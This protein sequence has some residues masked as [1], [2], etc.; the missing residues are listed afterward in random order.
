LK[1]RN[2]RF[3]GVYILI[4]ENITPDAKKDEKGQKEPFFTDSADSF[5][6][7]FLNKNNPEL[8]GFY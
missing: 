1:L 8:Q 4:K 3:R 5:L 2:A 7:F 6:N